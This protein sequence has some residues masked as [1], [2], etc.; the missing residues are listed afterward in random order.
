MN[1]SSAN[2]I[3]RSQFT[4]TVAVLIVL[5][6]SCGV[7]KDYPVQEPF[8]YN[9]SIEVHGDYTR[10]QRKQLISQ[11]ANQLHDSI[12]VRRIQRLVG[13]ENGPRILYSVL[14]SPPLYDS[15]NADKSV[16]FMRALL[17]SLGYYRDT[18]TYDTSLQIAGDQYRTTVNF[19]VVPGTLFRLDT[20]IYNMHDDTLQRITQ[21]AAGEALIKKGEAFSKPLI[22]AEID[23][24]SDVYRNNGYL[25]FSREELIA[26]WDTVG[27]AL[28]RPTFDPFE[29]AS[30]LEA[31]QRRRQNPTADVEIRLRENPDTTHLIRYYNGDVTIYPD[32]TIDTAL[33]FPTVKRVN[34]KTIIEYRDLFND[35]VLIENVYLNRGELYSQRNYLRTINRF[36]ALGAWR[37]VSVDQVP[38]TDSDTVDFVVKLTP[39]AKYAFDINL[40]GSQNWGVA[41]T[42]GNLIGVSLGLLNRNFARASNRANTTLRL[43]TD[44]N[45]RDFANTKQVSLANTIYFPRAIPRMRWLPLVNENTRTSF[46]LNGSYVDRDTIFGNVSLNTS[47]GYEF[48][49]KNKLLTLRIPNIEYSLLDVRRG[50]QGLIDANES[51]RFIFNTGF[52]S[53]VIA[54]YN[55]RGGKNDVTNLA[56]FSFEGSGLL[57]G[58][59]RSKF[60]DSN[61][62]RFIKLDADFRQTYKIRRTA[63]AWRIFGGVGYELPSQYH[64]YDRYMPFFKAYF[65]GGANSMRAWPLRK[66]GPGSALKSF[67]RTEAPDRFGDVQLELNA[68]YRFFIADLKGIAINSVLFTDIGNIWYLRSNPDF[69]GGRFQLNELGKDIAIGAG[70]GLRIDFGF[71]LLRVDYAYKVK[72]PSPDAGSPELQNKLFPNWR[73]FNGQIQ[74]GVTYPF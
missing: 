44:L 60:L 20:V 61:L 12:D 47:W 73:L 49:W 74:L 39:A 62:Y 65:A 66:L 37:L 56:R 35:R 28:L 70:T 42:E 55:I 71:F 9:H 6:S 25:R 5:F 27:I 45:P 10:D 72:D 24:L 16:I 26:V 18:I 21:D 22:S 34:D 58:F 23:R 40:E 38:R 46:A 59:I 32:L 29:Q 51:F 57:T 3:S 63:F 8:V 14:Q 36:N 69:P 50:L 11:L 30:Q 43:G 41:Y 33:Y 53:S 31:L 17:N 13:W 2:L 48:N 1:V 52:V 4:L 68:E 15:T 7:V 54:S 64:R 19:D 67:D